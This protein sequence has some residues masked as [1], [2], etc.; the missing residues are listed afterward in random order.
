MVKVGLIGICL[1]I[2]WAFR[3]SP[4][5]DEKSPMVL[6]KLIINFF[7][8]CLTLYHIP[9]ITF[10]SELIWLSLTPFIIYMFA[11]LFVKG[12]KLFYG[13]NKSSE[14]SLVMTSGIGSIS[15]VGFPIFEMLH[16]QEGLAYGIIMS[17]TGTLVVF[18]TI[19]IFTGL[20]YSKAKLG[21]K[22]FLLKLLTF[23]PL[24]AFV[25]AVVLKMTNVTLPES[26]DLILAK[27]IA[28]FS[29]LALITIGMQI[30]LSSLKLVRKKLLIGLLF[31][32]IL[33]PAM[34]YVLMWHILGY[35]DLMGRICILGAAIGSMTSISIVA[36]QL[37]LEPKLSLAAPAVSIPL[38][39]PILFLIDSIINK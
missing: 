36:A 38:S 32:C 13:L 21:Y 4:K 37:G 20:Y 18:N 34:I 14:G 31:K 2:G 22:G 29:V 33:A 3:H 7:I 1:L 35:Q 9:K 12:T 30:N 27:L 11:F 25:V 23:P 6:N 39:I 8:P 28:P 16:G 19:G 17:L 15:F 10:D 24:I 26:Y 5:F